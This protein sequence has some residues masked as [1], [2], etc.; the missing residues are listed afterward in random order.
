VEKN[1]ELL[2]IGLR[3]R[4]KVD[5]S[6]MWQVNKEKFANVKPTTTKGRSY[7]DIFHRSW[8]MLLFWAICFVLYSQAMQKKSKVCQDLKYKIKELESTKQLVLAEQEDLKLQIHSQSDDA[9]VEMV[10]K[11][12]L[13]VVPEGQ[14]KVYFKKDESY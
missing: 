8:W 10:L 12:R 5:G 3:V 13:G 11:K 7:L 14:M 9:W 4:V 2:T 6:D 1:K